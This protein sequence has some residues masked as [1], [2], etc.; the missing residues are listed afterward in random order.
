MIYFEH[1]HPL[2]KSRR[3]ACSLTFLQYKIVCRRFFWVRPTPDQP[4]FRL[5]D[6]SRSSDLVLSKG[7][8]AALA[9]LRPSIPFTNLWW[10][11]TIEVG[12]SRQHVWGNVLNLILKPVAIFK[13]QKI[14]EKNIYRKK[15]NVM[16]NALK[17]KHWC[18]LFVSSVTSSTNIVSAY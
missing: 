14:A 11:F 1:R 6:S 8:A 17:C 5:T 13:H 18:H 12:D 2:K 9:S 7:L 4:P 16:F 15:T 10:R 3:S